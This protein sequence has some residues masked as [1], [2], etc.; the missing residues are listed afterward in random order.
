MKV[1]NMATAP[2]PAPTSDIFKGLY[3]AIHV[4]KR[5]EIGQNILY[6]CEI[7]VLSICRHF[8]MLFQRD[9][10]KQTNCFITF[11]PAKVI[12]LYSPWWQVLQIKFQNWQL[13]AGHIIHDI[14]VYTIPKYSS[15][16]FVYSTILQY[17]L[18]QSSVSCFSFFCFFSL[19]QT[20]AMSNNICY[21]LTGITCI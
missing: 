11:V 13:P 10:N 20:L 5:S 2:I 15:K 3:V 17:V 14:K 19:K 21:L 9:I 16:F 12:T 8:N 4:S 6:V 7:T 18:C 1:N